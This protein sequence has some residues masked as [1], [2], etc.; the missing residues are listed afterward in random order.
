MVG[1][2]RLQRLPGSNYGLLRFGFRFEW[3]RLARILAVIHAE[4]WRGR[5]LLTQSDLMIDD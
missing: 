2:A 1:N 3:H 4:A 5:G